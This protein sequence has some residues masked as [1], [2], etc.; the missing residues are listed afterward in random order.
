[1]LPPDLVDLSEVLPELRLDL[2]YATTRNF[3]N[4]VFY[5]EPR[6]MLQR[7]AAWALGRVLETLRPRGLG[8]LVFDAYRPWSVTRLFFEAMPRE[9][10]HFVADPS[11]GSRHNRGCAV[12]LTLVDLTTGEPVE[13]QSGFDEFTARAH[14]RYP[15]GTARARWNRELLRCAMAEQGF[16]VFVEE[17]WHFDHQDWARYPI[18]DVQL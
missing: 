17:W 6:A 3:L 5:R 9:L 14:A 8:L 7:E 11:Q 10:R 13:M 16:T 2:R 4:S 12:D 18:L 15:G 1:M